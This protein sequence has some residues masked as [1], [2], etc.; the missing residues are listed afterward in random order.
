[1]FLSKFYSIKIYNYLYDRDK[2]KICK[3]ENDRSL[4]ELENDLQLKL[5][6]IFITI[7]IGCLLNQN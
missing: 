5:T 1:M 6:F 2:Y 3:H 4:G 7:I